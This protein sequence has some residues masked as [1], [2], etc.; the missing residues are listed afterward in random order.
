MSRSSQNN[1]PTRGP[2]EETHEK[3]STEQLR[4]L[5]ALAAIG[6]IALPIDLSR[7]ESQEAL[8]EIA[9]LRRQRLIEFICESIADDIHQTGHSKQS[10]SVQG[11]GPV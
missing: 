9:R 10:R 7:S 11:L 3:R 4:R 6:K 5:G 8:S 2:G 1:H